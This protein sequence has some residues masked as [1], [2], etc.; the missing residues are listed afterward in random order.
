MVED[1]L[2]LLWSAKLLLYR[3][4]TKLDCEVKMKGD[5]IW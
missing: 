1:A 3:S 5:V 2:I 4:S